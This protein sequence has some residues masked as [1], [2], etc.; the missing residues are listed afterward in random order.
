MD[1]T[2]CVNNSCPVADDCWRYGGPPNKY[3][4]SYQVFEPKQDDE[5]DFI[6][7]FYIPYPKN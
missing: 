2:M 3:Q 1:I 5:E 6:C 7:D 4:Q